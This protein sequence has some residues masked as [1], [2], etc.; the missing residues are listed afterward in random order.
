LE[1]KRVLKQAIKLNPF[2]NRPEIAFQPTIKKP[3]LNVFKVG[4]YCQALNLKP[5]KI[6]LTRPG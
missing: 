2:Q 1:F 4:F 6:K 5:S 3:T